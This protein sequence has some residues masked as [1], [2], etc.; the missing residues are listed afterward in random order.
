M[1]LEEFDYTLPAELIAQRPLA[2]RDTS[3]LLL[4]DRAT[5]QWDDR[6]F[7]EISQ[8]LQPG[9]LLV[10]NNTK[11]FPARLLGRRRGITSQPLGK[12]NPAQRGFLT[13]ETELFLTRQESEDVWQGLVHPGRKVR[14][15][16][17]L[18]FGDD[19]LEA[20]ILDRGEF[21]IRRARLRARTGTIED[22]LDRLGHVPLP[23]YIRRSDE[24]DDRTTYQTV[25][26]KVRGAVRPR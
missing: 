10:F 2:E 7:L 20:E 22:T 6:S 25:Y 17:V 26:A 13:G 14:T 18:V 24:A 15:G 12:N 8:L 21:G 3:R 5:H 11:V 4:L 16:E 1:L 23:P 19:E 9:D